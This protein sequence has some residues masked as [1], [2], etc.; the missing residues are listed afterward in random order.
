MNLIR[1]KKR[2]AAAEDEATERRV[3]KAKREQSDDPFAVD[4]KIVSLG[5]TKVEK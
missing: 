3:R 4:G 5:K 1:F 2:A